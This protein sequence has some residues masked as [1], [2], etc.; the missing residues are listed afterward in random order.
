MNKKLLYE[1]MDMLD[2][3]YIEEN[4]VGTNGMRSSSERN[5]AMNGKHSTKNMKKVIVLAIAACLMLSIAITAS[6]SRLWGVRSLSE[7]SG[8]DLPEEADEYIVVQNSKADTEEWSCT[9]TETICD[10]N[11][12]SVAIEVTCSD[13]YFLI[14]T[15]C[16]YDDPT[17]FIDIES[18]MTLGEYAASKGKELM[19]VNANLLDSGFDIGGGMVHFERV[20]DGQMLLLVQGYVEGDISSEQGICTVYVTAPGVRETKKELPFSVS[21]APITSEIIYLPVDSNIISGL[22]IEKATITET[23]LGI[24][25]CIEGTADDWDNIEKLDLVCE[26]ISGLTGGYERGDNGKWTVCRAQGQGNV[27]DTLIVHVYDLE[28]GKY[29]DDIVFKQS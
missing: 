1:V 21:E 26:G 25:V 19:K 4:I 13:K 2:E 10:H 20:S 27:T 16:G 11:E 7:E 15:D 12:I 28:T 9:V 23:P 8:R 3:A 18:D 5:F 24:S 22:Y 29:I 14:P 6:A 17:G